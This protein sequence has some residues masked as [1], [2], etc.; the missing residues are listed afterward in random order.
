MALGTGRTPWAPTREAFQNLLA[1]LDGDEERAA[2][3]YEELRQKLIVFFSGRDCADGDELADETLDRLTRRL[4]EGER[5]NDVQRFAYGIGRLVLAEWIRRS[6]TRRHLLRRACVT[7]STW[8]TTLEAADGVECVRCCASRLAPEDRQLI[9]AYYETAGGE[10]QRERKA[11]AERH[12]LSQGALRVRVHRI[13][14]SLETCTRRCMA[15][16]GPGSAR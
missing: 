4:Q 13:R 11:L 6:C 16:G 5:I 7:S 1:S 8:G 9:L 12:G 14:R 3:R 15:G 10:A 2:F